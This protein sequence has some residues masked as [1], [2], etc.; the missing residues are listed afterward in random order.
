AMDIR[1]I[2]TDKDYEQALA[3]IDRLIDAAPGS[4]EADRL[5]VISTLVAA[6]EDDHEPIAP[7]DPIEAIKFRMEQGGMDRKDLQSVLGV[8]QGRI[9]EILSGKRK[10]TVEMI[11]KLHEGWGVPVESLIQK[12]RP[13]AKRRTPS[14]ARAS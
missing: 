5:D 8:E 13:R 10:L 1:P 6:Y 3:E 14:T 12:S 2:R 9:S 4:R 11:R 7:P